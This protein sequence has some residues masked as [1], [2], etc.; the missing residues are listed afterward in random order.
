LEW[1]HR[2]R[3]FRFDEGTTLARRVAELVPALADRSLLIVLSDLH[4]PGA[5][6]ALR[7]AG[8]RHDCVVVQF[9]DPAEL[10]VRGAG[11]FRARE[12]ESG[13]EFVTRGRKPWSDPAAVGAELRRSGIDHMVLGTSALPVDAALRHFFGS[14]GTLGR[15]AR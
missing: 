10:G 3:H 11:L 9:Q 6:P 13:Q 8:Q 5:V 12:A 1:L 2:L 14:R 15:G 4:D 7:L